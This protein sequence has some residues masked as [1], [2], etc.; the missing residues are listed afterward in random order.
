LFHNLLFAVVNLNLSNLGSLHGLPSADAC[1]LAE[2]EIAA[3]IGSAENLVADPARASNQ[4]LGVSTA[5]TEQSVA[6][7][8]EPS[9]VAAPDE[10][11]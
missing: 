11:S 8:A 3:F 5:V 7:N 1:G 9:S 2:V 10:R 6:F 4:M